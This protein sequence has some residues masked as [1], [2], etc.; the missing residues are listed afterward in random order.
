QVYGF[1]FSLLCRFLCWMG[2][3]NWWLTLALFKLVNVAAYG[4]SAWL[5]WA[6][7]VRMGVAR[8]IRALY[9]FLWNPLILM[10]H[11]AN[12]HNDILTGCLVV[13]AMYLALVESYFW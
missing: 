2:G 11:I 13:L 3:G 8:P 12:G 9:L 4:F 10:H 1:L 7:A 5:V 6:G